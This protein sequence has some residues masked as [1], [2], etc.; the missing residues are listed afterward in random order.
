M[1]TAGLITRLIAPCFES[2][3]LTYA[4][5]DDDAG[6]APGQISVDLMIDHYGVDRVGP[7]TPVEVLIYSDPRREREAIAACRGD[8]SRLRIPLL[9]DENQS[10]HMRRGLEGLG[11]RITV[12]AM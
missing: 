3:L 11:P 6:T 1:G 5:A 4:S 2:C 7:L 12:S 9:V 10:V 8:G